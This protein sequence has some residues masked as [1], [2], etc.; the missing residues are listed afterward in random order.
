M[1]LT[2]LLTF[3]LYLLC[4]FVQAKPAVKLNRYRKA[5]AKN[6]F[7]VSTRPLLVTMPVQLLL[8]AHMSLEM[9]E[10]FLPRVQL[11]H[12]QIRTVKVFVKTVQK[13]RTAT[14]PRALRCLT[15]LRAVLARTTIS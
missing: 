7:L 3:F 15:A 8:L 11:V 4:L 2:F 1:S 5:A 6:A 13:A 10:H 9:V 12:I 14:K